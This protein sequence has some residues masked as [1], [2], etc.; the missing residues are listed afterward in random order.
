MILDKSVTYIEKGHMI[1]IP[2]SGVRRSGLAGPPESLA[3]E[4]RPPS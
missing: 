2:I 4:V 3:Y 1:K